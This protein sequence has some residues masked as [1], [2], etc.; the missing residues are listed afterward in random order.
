N[1][2]LT[3]IFNGC[4]RPVQFVEP[5]DITKQIARKLGKI[6]PADGQRVEWARGTTVAHHGRFVGDDRHEKPSKRRFTGFAES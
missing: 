4:D 5:A 2:S 1:H 6:Q 3:A